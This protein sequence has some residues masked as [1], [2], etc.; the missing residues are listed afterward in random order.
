MEL[1]LL[2]CNIASGPLEIL[3]VFPNPTYGDLT[4]NFSSP[5]NKPY[6]L[7]IFNSIGDLM[8]EQNF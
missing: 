2:Y 1:A 8:L 3:E 5:D 4:I 6:N 7:R